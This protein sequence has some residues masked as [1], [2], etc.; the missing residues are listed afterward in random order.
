MTGHRW[1]IVIRGATLF[2][3]TGVAP[4]VGDLS[5]LGDRIAAIGEIEGTG[6]AIEIDARGLALAP[7]FIDVHSHDDFAVLTTPAMDSS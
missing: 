1:D 4:S 6:A 3:G 5:V 7:G 2:D